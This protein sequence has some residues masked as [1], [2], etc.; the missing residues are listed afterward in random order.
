MNPKLSESVVYTKK[1]TNIEIITVQHGNCYNRL[2]TKD[3]RAK[4]NGTKKFCLKKA[5]KASQRRRQW[6]GSWSWSG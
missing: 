2:R 4:G 3:F 1:H 5:K 6:N